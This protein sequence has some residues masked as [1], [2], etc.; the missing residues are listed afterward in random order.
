MTLQLQVATRNKVN[1]KANYIRKYMQDF[2][3]QYEGKK[4]IR[5]TPYKTWTKKIE[6]ELQEFEK[7]LVSQKFRI[8][9]YFGE[10]DIRANLDATYSVS[11]HGVN[12]VKQEFYICSLDKDLLKGFNKNVEDF[13]TDYTE[14]EVVSTREK[15]KLLDGQVRALE[16]QIREFERN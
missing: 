16:S 15:I 8:W 4:I 3:A 5:V 9:F 10:Y 14:E 11:D 12:Y 13:R 6:H 1:S 7:A 2:L